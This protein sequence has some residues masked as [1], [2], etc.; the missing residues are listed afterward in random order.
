MELISCFLN[1]CYP[2]RFLNSELGSNILRWLIVRSGYDRIKW[3]TLRANATLN[4]TISCS[5]IFNDHFI[6]KTWLTFRAHNKSKF[7]KLNIFKKPSFDEETTFYSPSFNTL[8][9]SKE[10]KSICV[11]LFLCASKLWSSGN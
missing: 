2:I 6:G 3:I 4:L 10:T 7:G 5:S 11:T 8:Y 9:P 1:F